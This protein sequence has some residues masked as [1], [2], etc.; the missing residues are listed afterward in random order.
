MYG[1]FLVSMPFLPEYFLH[2]FE[3]CNTDCS[4]VGKEITA[5]LF[6]LTGTETENRLDQ[7]M[8]KKLR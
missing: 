3:F 2:I 8:G 1:Y 4:L 6:Q 5:F 7:R